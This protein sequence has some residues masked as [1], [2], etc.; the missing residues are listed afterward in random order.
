MLPVKKRNDHP[1][2]EEIKELFDQWRKKK[3]GRD[4][5]PEVLWA[6]AV[7]LTEHYSVHKISRYLRLNFN[8]VKARSEH[9]RIAPG[10]DDGAPAFVEL[11]PIRVAIGYT[12]EMEKPTGERM[13]IKGNCNVAELAREFFAA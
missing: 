1:T 2:L 12:I 11:D 13:R 8:D 9:G 5:I 10:K 4:S 6:Q 7:S 3:K